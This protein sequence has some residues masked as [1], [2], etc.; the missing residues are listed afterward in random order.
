MGKGLIPICLGIIRDVNPCCWRWSGE[1]S[2]GAFNLS[3]EA[4]GTSTEGAPPSLSSSREPGSR[5]VFLPA[6]PPDSSIDLP[7]SDST[8]FTR[9]ACVR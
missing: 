4:A 2:A 8:A 3:P 5:M 6:S 7:E 1:G 9:R